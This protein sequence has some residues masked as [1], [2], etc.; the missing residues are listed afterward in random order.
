MLYWA[1]VGCTLLYWAL[2]GCIGLCWA[3]LGCT[4]MHWAVMNCTVR[5]VRVVQA[6][7]VVHV[8]KVVM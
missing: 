4:G 7:R 8:V 1:L 3:V 5:V 6:G 2:L